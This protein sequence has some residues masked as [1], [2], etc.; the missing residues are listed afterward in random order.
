VME[1]EASGHVIESA[2]SAHQCVESVDDSAQ[3]L[4]DDAYSVSADDVTAELAPAQLGA[5][6]EVNV[7]EGDDGD[8]PVMSLDGE[9]LA[10]SLAENNAEFESTNKD[11]TV[12]LTGSAGSAKPKVVAGSSGRGVDPEQV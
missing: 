9:E 3:S 12:E 8:T 2:I 7:E 4:T 11:A 10:D 5:A 6:A 1:L